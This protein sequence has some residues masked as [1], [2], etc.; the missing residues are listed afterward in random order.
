VVR[1][2][3]VEQPP[4]GVLVVALLA[5]PDVGIVWGRRDR[6]LGHRVT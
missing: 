2:A 1:R 3:L 4:Y 6:G 5:P